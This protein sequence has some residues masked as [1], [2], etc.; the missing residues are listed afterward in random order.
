MSRNEM[1]FWPTL[2]SRYSFPRFQWMIIAMA[3]VSGLYLSSQEIWSTVDGRPYPEIADFT[4]VIYCGF[5]LTIAFLV[6]IN[7]MRSIVSKWSVILSVALASIM[8]D[9]G[10]L[11]LAESV[12]LLSID[13]LPQEPLTIGKLLLLGAMPSSLGVVTLTSLTVTTLRER[14]SRLRKEVH[15]LA[16]Q[17]EDI[18]KKTEEARLSLVEFEKRK[19]DFIERMERSLAKERQ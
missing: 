3:S 1:R 15:E 2:K 17:A 7:D 16:K 5:F 8:L 19:R 11:C 13:V 4:F 18:D 10:A 14:A 9:V 6:H 12:T